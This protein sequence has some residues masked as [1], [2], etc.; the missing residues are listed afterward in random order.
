MAEA[1]T[2]F[3]TTQ[4][5][6]AR[7][8]RTYF[9]MQMRILILG[10]ICITLTAQVF[11]DRQ[12][13]AMIVTAIIFDLL[14]TLDGIRLH[15]LISGQWTSDYLRSVLDYFIAATP[16]R[17][18]EYALLALPANALLTYLLHAADFA[19]LNNLATL[20]MAYTQDAINIIQQEASELRASAMS[21]ALNFGFTGALEYVAARWLFAKRRIKIKKKS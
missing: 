8:R 7:H 11:L 4:D 20:T 14:R 15:R 9:F 13:I 18:L 19:E 12:I 10:A 2:P 3:T 21:F 16:R 17:W 1:T 6:I 5:S